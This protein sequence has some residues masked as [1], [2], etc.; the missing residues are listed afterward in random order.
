MNT[1]CPSAI[2]FALLAGC[3]DMSGLGGSTQFACK[4]P[5]GV[6]CESLSATYYNSLADNLPAQ[7]PVPPP[8]GRPGAGTGS[9]AAAALRT[10]APPNT[11]YAPTA[12]RAPGR[13][14]RVWIK[15]W[16][17]D[18]KDL[19]DQS[20]VYLVVSEGEWRV[21]HVQRQERNAFARL[22]EPQSPKQPNGDPT[23]Q[24]NPAIP[25][26]APSPA[27]VNRPADPSDK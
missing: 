13:E 6:H 1:R 27:L 9:P 7:R 10:A 15:A 16:Q 12:L 5:V 4:A 26:V 23:A 25:A 21:A 17:D 22:A 18:D 19:V 2:F 8:V 24:E 3:G 11:G 20:Y 14:M